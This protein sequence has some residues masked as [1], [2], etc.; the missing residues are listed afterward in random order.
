[1]TTEISFGI[2]NFGRVMEEEDCNLDEKLILVNFF[3]TSF[4]IK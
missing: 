3:L 2:F 1:M 4:K